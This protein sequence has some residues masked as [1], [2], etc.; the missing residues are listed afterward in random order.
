MTG[1][2]V[3]FMLFLACAAAL[4]SCVGDK[5]DPNAPTF[6]DAVRTVVAGLATPTPN[7]CGGTPNGTFSLSSLPAT[8]IGDTSDDTNNFTGQP[9]GGVTG[10]EWWRFTTFSDPATLTLDLCDPSWDTCL[11]VR[12]DNGDICTDNTLTVAESDDA[13]SCAV[14]TSSKITSY[15]FLGGTTY[16]VIVDGKGSG[17]TGPYTL[18]V[19]SP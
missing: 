14:T 8:L 18:I 7:P 3:M 6:P 1:K 10:D 9:C 15:V 19:T 4:A 5:R 17:S 13:S 16:N 2:H 11:Y 12:K